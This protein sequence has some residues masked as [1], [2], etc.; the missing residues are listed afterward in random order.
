MLPLNAD[1]G[2]VKPSRFT[3]SP[4]TPLHVHAMHASRWPTLGRGCTI[5]VQTSDMCATCYHTIIIAYHFPY[6]HIT[7]LNNSGRQ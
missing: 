7:V 3:A 2:A 5:F 1:G 6:D 4:C